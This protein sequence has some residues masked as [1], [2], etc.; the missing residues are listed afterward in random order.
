MSAAAC[1]G[2]ILPPRAQAAR[3]ARSPRRARASASCRSR[4]TARSLW[5]SSAGAVSLPN[6]AFSVC[7][8]KAITEAELA[9]LAP[10]LQETICGCGVDV[11]YAPGL[12]CL[13]NLAFDV[14]A[15]VN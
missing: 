10:T 3:N 13:N 2:F 15:T 4:L 12:P 11:P 6:V 14:S 1:S 5:S 9:A 8:K 7:G